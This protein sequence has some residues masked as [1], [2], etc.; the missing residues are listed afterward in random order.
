MVKDK[1]LE[2]LLVISTQYE[3]QLK[4]L[5]PSVGD[6]VAGLVLRSG[7]AAVAPGVLRKLDK[8]GISPGLLGEEC[9]R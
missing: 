3:A 7:L 6:R 1:H 8:V 9:K 5:L 4:V 2:D